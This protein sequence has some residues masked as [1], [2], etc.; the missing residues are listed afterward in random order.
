MSSPAWQPK[1]MYVLG[2][3]ELFERMSYY[4]LSFLLVLYA[5]DS[6]AKGG[7]GW[8]KERALMLVGYYTLA[9]YTLP[10]LGSF[11]ADKAIGTF[12]SALLGA[13]LIIAGHSCMMLSNHENLFYF[14]YN[15]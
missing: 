1:G 14:L 3:T 15:Q 9:A 8:S 2:F 11:L 6:V 10:L 5:S 12:R 7:L 13:V 4:T